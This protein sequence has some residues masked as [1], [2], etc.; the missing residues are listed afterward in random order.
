[1][2]VAIPFF[3]MVLFYN[4]FMNTAL[5]Q[6]GQF[7]KIFNDFRHFFMSFVVYVVL[8]LVL[9]GYRVVCLSIVEHIMSIVV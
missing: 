1:M 3:T 6:Q 9:R 7:S 8:L 4:I 5:L 2:Q